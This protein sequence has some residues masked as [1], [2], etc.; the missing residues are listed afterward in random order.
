MVQ[1]MLIHRHVVSR[2]ILCV[3]SAQR[4]HRL[5]CSSSASPASGWYPSSA[6]RPL[7]ADHF[8][9][10]LLKIVLKVGIHINELHPQ[11][12]RHM[13]AMQ[14]SQRIRH[15]KRCPR[16]CSTPCTCSLCGCCASCAFW[17]FSTILPFSTRLPLRSAEAQIVSTRSTLCWT[18]CSMPVIDTHHLTIRFRH[19]SHFSPAHMHRE[20]QTGQDVYAYAV[21]H[22]QFAHL[23][24]A[25][26][27][28]L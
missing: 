1:R 18:N 23:H 12:W 6:P 14:Q 21:E 5:N 7:S 19:H 24:Q 25:I 20:E 13:H 8:V 16:F 10:F 17:N 11:V 26:Q 9:D 22:L 15:R 27:R 4:R 3:C 2:R 28:D